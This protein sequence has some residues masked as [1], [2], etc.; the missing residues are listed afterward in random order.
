[1]A[2][3]GMT[4]ERIG[5]LVCPI[6]IAGIDSKLPE[7][8]AIGVAAQLLRLREADWDGASAHERGR[9]AVQQP[10]TRQ[11]AIPIVVHRN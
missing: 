10:E 3:E 5:Q 9:R 4:A 11:Q 2:R 6:G 7:A 8:I 1:M